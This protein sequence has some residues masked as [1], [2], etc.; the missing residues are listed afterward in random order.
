MTLELSNWFRERVMTKGEMLSIDRA[1]FDITGGREH[2]LYRVA[3]AHAGGAREGKTRSR[4]I[5]LAVALRF[6]AVARANN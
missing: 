1:Y 4:S 2:W 6:S 5:V 3:R